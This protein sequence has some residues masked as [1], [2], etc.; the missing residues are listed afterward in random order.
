MDEVWGWSRIRRY[1]PTGGLETQYFRHF[2]GLWA[3]AY[4]LPLRPRPLFSAADHTAKFR[5]GFI[6]RNKEILAVSDQNAQTKN[7]QQR[8]PMFYERPAPVSASAH[9][10]FKARPEMDFAFAAKSNTTPLTAPEFVLVA[11]HYPIIFVGDQMVPSAVMGLKIDENLYVSA[12]GEWDAYSYVPA[13]IRRFPF[14]LL[15]NQGD[16]RLQLGVEET[17]NSTKAGARALFEG[18]KETE[19][20]RQQL[21]MC[22]QFHNAY[23]YTRDFSQAIIDAKLIEERELNVPIS[24]TE[25][26]KLGTFNAVNEEK[27]KDLPDATVL[28]WKKKGFLHAV[29]FH[30][31]SL[32]NWEILLAKANE[33]AAISA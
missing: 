27:F 24:A 22:E 33:R 12:K 2:S 13:Y 20:V 30:L 19:F 6:R 23:L 16:E 21:D 15:G 17:A 32:N 29:Y 14:I 3:Y 5:A 10:K 18:E 25:T 9:G 11:R 7:D 8:P 1:W 31:Q 26:A 28:D 4:P